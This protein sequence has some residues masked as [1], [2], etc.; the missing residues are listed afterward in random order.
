LRDH[1]AEQSPLGQL[2]LAEK[3]RSGFGH[4]LLLG[5]ILKL[6]GSRFGLHLVQESARPES[7]DGEQQTVRRLSIA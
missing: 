5:D 3:A 2:D 4:L 6:L 7:G 1:Q